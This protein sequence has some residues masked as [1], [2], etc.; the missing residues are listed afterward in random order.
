MQAERWKKVEQFY[1]A[2]LA[3]PR[4]KRDEFLA[5]TCADDAEL[6]EEVR[7][8]LAQNTDSFL[9]SAPLAAKNALSAGSK[10]GNFEILELIGCGGM[11]E[12]Y[13]ARDARLG[14]E[15]A[16]KVC[17][18]HFTERFEREARTI[19]QLNHPARAARLPGRACYN[20]ANGADRG[21]SP[22]TIRNRRSHRRRG[23]G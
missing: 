3:V 15:V 13:R 12:V 16:I 5:S 23:N 11:G 10:L 19:A 8:L 1:Q 18:E 7:S 22:G 14:R 4:E 20:P 17:A 2:A 6:R 21:D 9:E